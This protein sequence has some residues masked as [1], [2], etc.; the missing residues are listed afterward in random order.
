MKRTLGRSG[1]EITALGMGCWAIGGPMSMQGMQLG[2]GKV[3]DEVSKQALMKAYEMGVNFFDTADV[4]GMGHS[5]IL[6][7]EVF[8]GRREELVIATKFGMVFNESEVTGFDASPD[9]IKKAVEASLKRLKTDYIDLYQLHLADY[10]HE[11]AEKTMEA[12][13][14]LVSAGKIRAYGWSTDNP[15][16]AGFFAK[17]KNCA[18]IQQELNLFLGN[19]EV[20]A[21]CEKENLASLNRGPLAM[22][23]LSGKFNKDS[24]FP[25]DDCRTIV[26]KN[27]DP[28][29]LFFRDGKPIPELLNQLDA[30]K[31]ILQSEGRT[32]AQ[33]ALAWIWAKSGSTIPIPGF[34][35]AKQVEENAGA[36]A[37]GPLK[38]AQMEEI[39]RILTS[40]REG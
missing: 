16:H 23:I 27:G 13:E 40:M 2:W 37:F 8:S 14:D 38:S 24:V 6:L 20:L 26:D 5:E 9:Y 1:I 25:E 17:G 19:K 7:G 22:G 21:L 34:K 18:A 29:Y 4:Y 12:L 39:D 10:P 31:E 15:E 32:V 3:D 28:Y 35:T 11:E 33:G 30:V 36:M